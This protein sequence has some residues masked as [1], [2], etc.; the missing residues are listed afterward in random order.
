MARGNTR[1]GIALLLTTL[2][3][4][5][6]IYSGQAEA[7]GAK[8]A[9]AGA[10]QFLR[11]VEPIF[12]K[13]GCS[14]AA[15]HGKFGGRGGFQLSLLTLTP[16]DDY[17]PVV[18]GGRGRRVNL[19]EPEKSLLLQKATNGTAHMGG[20]R[21]AVN[22]AEYR[23]IRDW[24][25]AGAPYD[26]ASDAVLEKLTVTPNQ[27]TLNKVGQLVPLKVMASFSDGKVRDVTAQANY[28]TSDP[29]VL[30]V[31]DKGVLK[32][33]RWGGAAVIVRYLGNIQ[34]VAMTLPREDKAPYPKL[35]SA[36]LIDDLVYANLKRLRVQPSRPTT[37]TEFLRRISLDLRGVLPTPEEVATFVADKA[38]DKRTKQIDTYLDSPEFVDMRTLRL[39]DMLRVHPRNLGNNI[40]GERSAAIFTE[41]LHDSVAQNVPY[42]QLVKQI[43]LAR[44]SSFNNGPANFYKIDRT[45]E[46]R[47]ET[48]AQA[49]LGQRMACARCHK[50]PFDRWTTDDYW[51][52]AAFMGRV[53]TRQGNL[54]GESE[55]FYNAG[56]RVV[57]QS[58]TGRNRGKI[59]PPTLLGSGQ[60]VESAAPAG[61]RRNNGPDLVALLADWVTSKD[62]PYFARAT[63]NRLWS[64]YLGR[65]VIHPV[66]DM[67]A[68]TPE[69]VPGL[70]DAL[71]KDFVA[72]GYDLKH[73]I[74]LILN[75]KTYQTSSEVNGTNALDN[76]FFSHFYPRPML[77]QV[78]LDALNQ[79]TGSVERFG[80]FP[81]DYR[82]AQ[83]SLPVG[84]FF[85]DCFGRS[86]RE[87]LAELEPKVE[88]TLVQVLHVLNSPYV[89]GKVR[90]GNG[91][92]STLLKDKALSNA[93]LVKKL[94][95]KTFSRQPTDTELATA[96]KMLDAAPKRDE[97]A[98]D[99]MWALI[100]AREFYF[101]S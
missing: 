24:I 53:G 65:G 20:E 39:S 95:L 43:L 11:D 60:Q 42:D 27:V 19:I 44:G 97:A 76:Q 84:S 92:V 89:D 74:R 50:H 10:P 91:T 1:M 3:G 59:A 70:L 17:D 99:L 52:F 100:S 82:V 5:G 86:Q 69:A 75:S 71:A 56:G 2:M 45:P 18:R 80:D 28:E 101:V 62:N 73:T 55:I 57:N 34:S 83:L 26:E 49:F 4:F 68:T 30:S 14:V 37:D 25:A 54:D 63:V 33:M 12:D 78:M 38:P 8:K 67:R 96:V 6:A 41:W 15:C 21:F 31:S 40:S 85:L 29:A 47:M 77:G 48:A 93:D 81:A 36:N 58:V 98:Q 35:A 79:A 7:H 64:H 87:F 61:T 23:T 51:N 16:S 22:S 94:Y 90:A 32:G 9:P 88:P 46:D 66:D 13:K 72:N